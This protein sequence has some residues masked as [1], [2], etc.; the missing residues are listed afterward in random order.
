M[1]LSIPSQLAHRPSLH[2]DGPTVLQ[3]RAFLQG[4]SVGGGV[5]SLLPEELRLVGCFSS[6]L[7]SNRKPQPPRDTQSQWM[8]ELPGSP[9]LAD[10]TEE[11]IRLNPAYFLCS[12]F[13]LSP[14]NTMGFYSDKK[15]ESMLF[16]RKQMQLEINMLSKLGQAKKDKYHVLSHL[17]IQDCVCGGVDR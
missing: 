7:I 15:N 2:P 11:E 17:W 4:L 16:L 6:H 10:Y 8:L 14:A 13:S 3:L 1:T 5:G 9:P 12:A